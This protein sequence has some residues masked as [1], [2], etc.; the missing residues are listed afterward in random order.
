VTSHLITS[1]I[2]DSD[3]FTVIVDR[4]S[5]FAVVSA[6]VRLGSKT[7]AKVWHVFRTKEVITRF[8]K[9][10]VR[11]TSATDTIVASTYFLL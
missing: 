11:T 6:S 10:R 9:N 5:L 1:V 4:L 7:G 2:A 3:D 8:F